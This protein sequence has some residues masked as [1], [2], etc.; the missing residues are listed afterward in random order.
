MQHVTRRCSDSY[1]D[2]NAARGGSAR[3]PICPCTKAARLFAVDRRSVACGLRAILRRQPALAGAREPARSASRRAPQRVRAHAS[4][5]RDPIRPHKTMIPRLRRRASR[6]STATAGDRERREVRRHE[7]T[8]AH[9]TLPFGT[10]CAH[11]RQDRPFR[12]RP[13]QRSRPYVP[14]RIVDVS[15]SAAQSLGMI[16]KGV[17]NVRLDVVQAAPAAGFGTFSGVGK[18]P[19]LV[20]ALSC[21]P[22]GWPNKLSR[23]FPAPLFQARGFLPNEPSSPLAS[24]Q[25][26]FFIEGHAR[27][28]R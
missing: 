28:I 19:G 1:V 17:A 16:G 22:N 2:V 8:A 14:G 26:G 15:Y 24:R 10:S 9:P 25:G 5:P 11:R 13:R 18:S 6:A 3:D 7:L 4:A 20:R 27:R 12:H 23:Y 21:C